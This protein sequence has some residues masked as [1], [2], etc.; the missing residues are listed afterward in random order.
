MKISEEELLDLASGLIRVESPYFH[1]ENVM[2]YAA[3]W[4]AEHELAPQRHEYSED[5]VTRFRGTNI[6]GNIGG[7][8]AGVRILLNAH[9]DTVN[10]CKGWTQDPYAAKPEGNR[11]Y[12]LGAL[13][14]KSGAAAMM[15]AMDAFRRDHPVFKGEI[16][17]SL[18]SDEEGPYGLG[19]RSLIRDGLCGAPDLALIPEPSSGFSRRAFPC[20]CLG[21]RGGYNYTVRFTGKSA[22]AA[23]PEQGISAILDAARVMIEMKEADTIPDDRLGRGSL[24][25]IESHGGGQAC[26]VADDAS[27]TVFQHT[28]RGEDRA[29]IEAEIARAAEKAGVRSGLEVSFREGVFGQDG[30]FAPYTVEETSPFTVKLL[31]CARKVSGKP[32]EIAYFSSIGD[33]NTVASLLSVPTFVFGPDGENFHAADEFVYVDTMVKTSETIYAFLESLLA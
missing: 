2:K 14:M 21:A 33:F 23:T 9:L 29:Y 32:A 8:T 19:T 11:L 27:F 5:S 31:E 28:V 10:L 7:G 20:V 16:V 1:E 4:L 25:V 18:V 12:G 22:H 26:S 24:C 6:V 13:D 3:A 15:I 30:G 17:Y